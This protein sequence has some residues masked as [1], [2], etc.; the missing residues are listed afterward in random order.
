MFQSRRITTM[1]GD[2]FRD[3]FSL[4]FDGTDDYVQLG[5]P[6]NHTNITI[7]SWIKVTDDGDYKTIFSNR[8][9]GTTKGILLYVNGSEEI[10]FKVENVNTTG[11]AITAGR[12]YHIVA[13]YNGINQ[14]VYVDGVLMET[15]TRTETDLDT[16]TNAMIGGD[17]LPASGSQYF[18]NGNISEV[19]I[20]NTTLTA[21]QI[22]V[23]YNSGEIFNYLDHG[24]LRLHLKGWYRMGDGLENHS[25]T[26]IYDMSDNSNNGTMTNMAAD[27]FQGDT[28]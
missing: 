4:A 19:V 12:W 23:I 11:V 24:Y 2:K 26:T 14:K 13:T 8:K 1:G 9:N 27:D 15:E 25:G 5:T 3:E 10:V 17:S 20:Y 21:Q 16:D 6:F 7:A 22:K 28:P 18:F